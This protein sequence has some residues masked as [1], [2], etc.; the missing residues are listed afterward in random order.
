MDRKPISYPSPSSSFFTGADVPLNPTQTHLALIENTEQ[1]TRLIQLAQLCNHERLL[2][3]MIT[4]LRQFMTRS[5]HYA[6]LS[7]AL[8]DDLNLR[9]LRGAA[10]LEV[11]QRG[12]FTSLGK[13]RTTV[14]S[15]QFL[16]MSCIRFNG[17]SDETEKPLEI[18]PAQQVRL[19]A[20]YWHLTR[21]WERFRASP[22]P[23]THA[24]SC[25]ATWHQAGCTS[26]A[27][28]CKTQATL[29]D[30]FYRYPGLVGILE[31]YIQGRGC[32]VSGTCRCYWETQA[33][34]EGI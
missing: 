7:M 11:M 29:S 4:L 33:D 15:E 3:S 25:S 30:F 18:T 9:T 2:N 34:P 31:G 13:R 6:H 23:F 32:Y 22:P 14:E 5:L 21:T 12:S 16:L 10:Y 20:G 1:L 8:A 27:Y 26:T 19:L 17:F 28:W 24:P